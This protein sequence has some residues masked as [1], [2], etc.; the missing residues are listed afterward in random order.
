[1]LTLALDHR[2]FIFTN[3]IFYLNN[4]FNN[5]QHVKPVK[6][7]ALVKVRGGGGSLGSVLLRVAHRNLH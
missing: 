5:I 3:R 4:I 1:M 2:F 6:A 7:A